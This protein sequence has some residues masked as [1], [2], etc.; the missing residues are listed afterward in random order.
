[1]SRIG[2]VKTLVRRAS[3]FLNRAEDSLR[4]GDYDVAVFE[5]EQAV[6]LMLKAVLIHTTGYHPETH[7]I[8]ELLGAYH[9]ATGDEWARELALKE[10]SRLRRLEEAYTRARYSPLTYDREEAESLVEL[11]ELIVER[12]K[13]ILERSAQT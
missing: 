11:A 6:Q 1:M 13:R 2:Y 8:R 4:L 10:R 12:L 7:G 5:A 9:H 3:A